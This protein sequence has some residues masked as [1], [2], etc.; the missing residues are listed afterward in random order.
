MS[1]SGLRW[2]RPA[3]RAFALSTCHSVTSRC[4]SAWMQ[5]FTVEAGPL[6]CNN[7]LTCVW[8]YIG[9]MNSMNTFLSLGCSCVKCN[10]LCVLNFAHVTYI[11]C[12]TVVQVMYMLYMKSRISC[13]PGVDC[14]HQRLHASAAITPNSINPQGMIRN[15]TVVKHESLKQSLLSAR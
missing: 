7:R 8:S 2:R 12:T 15:A 11:T 13:S 5:F 6:V 9:F 14:Q 4:H 3:L 1:Y 10:T